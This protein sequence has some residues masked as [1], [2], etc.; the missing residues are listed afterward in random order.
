M[1]SILWIIIVLGVIALLEIS[2]L[3]FLSKKNNEIKGKKLMS[4]YPPFLFGMF[5]AEWQLVFVIVLA[6]AVIALAV[7]SI[8]F[9]T[10][11]LNKKT[12]VE[13]EDED[14]E[15]EVAEENNVDQTIKNIDD[16]KK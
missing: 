1:G 3:V 6:V 8:I 9:A 7:I 12:Q 13:T 16:D 15:I 14:E 10:K 11:V 5:I 4:A 2:F